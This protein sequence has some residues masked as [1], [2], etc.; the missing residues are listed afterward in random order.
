M[1]T[2]PKLDGAGQ[3]KLET[4]EEAT[5]QLQRL[6]GIVERM[7]VAVRTQQDTAQFGAQIRRTGAPLAGLLKGQF[8]MIAD[9]VTAM[10]L[11]ATRGGG[12]QNK[13]RALRESVAQLRMQIEIAIARTK[14]KHTI[15]DD[16]H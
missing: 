2:G 12:E 3:A 7:A 8:G 15:P 9:Q 5:A 4:L 16:P 14:E 1:A 10:L 11:V 6:H 13:V